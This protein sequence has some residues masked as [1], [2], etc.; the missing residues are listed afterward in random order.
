MKIQLKPLHEQ[1]IV[2]TGASSGIGLATA[3]MAARRGARVVLAARAKDALEQLETE[4]NGQRKQAVHVA[5]DVTKQ[6]DV[7]RIAE[8]AIR[9]FGGIDTW[10]NDAGTSIY[11]HIT[12]I[13]VEDERALF[14]VNY[15]GFVYGCRVAI[16]SM[17]QNG[18]AI[19]SLGS[20]ASDRAV[21]LQ[22]AYSA[23]KHALKAY[24]DA[25]RV[26]FQEQNI[27]IAVTVIKPT[28]I[29]T[30]IFEHAKNYMEAEPKEPSPMYTP[31]LVAEAILHA[32]EHPTRDLLIGDNAPV[33]SLLGTLAPKLG[34][35]FMRFTM[36]QGQKS[37]RP[38]NP[39][40]H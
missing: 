29:N 30:P 17:R 26:E 31:D 23:T 21:P 13:P 12:E 16:E 39:G 35:K 37:S 18:G 5:A 28:G 8:T 14:E 22:G 24:S 1:V 19:I 11:G 34:D 2:I 33:Q 6:E 7:R 38:P 10:V 3:R 4:L 36:F 9:E 25:L 32:A 20:V 27:P 15:W 40:D